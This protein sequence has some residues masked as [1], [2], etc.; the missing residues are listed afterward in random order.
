M[1]IFATIGGA[2]I[3]AASN[4]IGGK[5]ASDKVSEGNDALIAAIMEGQ[6]L[7]LEEIRSGKLQ[8]FEFLAPLKCRLRRSA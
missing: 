1:S 4:L 2:L 6:R 5:I 7:A 3:G 8:A